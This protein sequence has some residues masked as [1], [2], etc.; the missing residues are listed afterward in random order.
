[1]TACG[2]F[3][4][5]AITVLSTW[6]TLIGSIFLAR[7]VWQANKILQLIE[8]LQT[9]IDETEA[10]KAPDTADNPLR[11]QARQ[12][13]RDLNAVIVSLRKTI[14]S[15]KNKQDRWSKSNHWLM[16]FGILFIVAGGGLA[17]AAAYGTAY[18]PVT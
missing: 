10:K 14:A 12:N 4:G 7:P 9:A 3:E 18:C 11:E 16:R 1:M 6:L 5:H 13:R 8:P 2:F 15:R 17:V